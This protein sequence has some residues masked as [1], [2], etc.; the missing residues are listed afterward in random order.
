MVRG[1]RMVVAAEP[2]GR[3]PF[4]ELSSDPLVWQQVTVKG[5]TGVPFG[6]F[7]RAMES[8]HAP[9][10][11]LHKLHTRASPIKAAERALKMLAGETGE[12]AFH[13]AIVPKPRS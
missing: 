13:V 5:V 8:I 1:V 4:S 3:R 10:Y 6:A 7:Q 11:P 2:K 9:R 12:A